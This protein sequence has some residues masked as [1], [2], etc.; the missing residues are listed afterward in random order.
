M[1]PDKI[2]YGKDEFYPNINNKIYNVYKIDN[3]KK[4]KY[5]NRIFKYF[6]I[7]QK[8]NINEKHFIGIDFEFNK[9]S[10]NDRDVAMM[11]INL[12]NNL[13]IGYIFLLYPPDLQ[14]KS[15]KRLIKLLTVSEFIKILHG[16][17]SLDIPYLF[18]QLLIKKKLINKFCKN[19]YDTKYICDYIN[20][21]MKAQT[22]ELKQ[23]DGVVTKSCSIYDFLLDNK[24]VTKNQI[25]MLEK[26]EEMMGPI[27]L[28]NIN[29]YKLSDSLF[30]YTLYDVLYLPELIKKFID[31]N[32]NSILIISELSGLV[33]KYKRNIENK[34]N[35]LELQINNINNYFFIYKNKKFTLLNIW[36]N[37]YST[38]NDINI[39]KNIN[40]FKNFFKII[41]KYIV[42]YNIYLK[43]NILKKNKEQFLIND[44]DKYF[45]WLKLYPNVYKL[46]L[47]Y[48]QLTLKYI[49]KEFF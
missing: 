32:D 3:I 29:I 13:E 22:L 39:F 40:Y 6:I 16:S 4:E 41:I 36:N 9:I 25:N 7:N 10:K 33:N 23:Q 30:N 31:I 43:F 14:L 12:E 47:T 21:N 19:F 1:K 5:M 38:I 24:I 34:F 26:N 35:N 11:Q 48:N 20:T 49:N 18:N 27:Y 2:L 28:I 45:K 15:K 42:Y 46:L 37:F 8:D 44:F 17:E